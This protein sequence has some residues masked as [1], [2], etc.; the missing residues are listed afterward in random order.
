MYNARPRVIRKDESLEENGRARIRS[1]QYEVPPAATSASKMACIMSRVG[2]YE[3]GGLGIGV[4]D[5]AKVGV[6][7]STAAGMPGVYTA[8]ALPVPIVDRT[9][10]TAA[11]A[12][13]LV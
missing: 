10:S 12:A 6:P 1:N 8:S 5:P 9:T 11:A 4:D 7:G 13:N 2:S 3:A